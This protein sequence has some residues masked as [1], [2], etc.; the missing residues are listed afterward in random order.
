MKI[1]TTNYFNVFIAVAEDCPVDV[2]L[3]PPKKANT[4]IAELQY[5]LISKNPYQ[6]T[7]DDVVFEVF[8]RKNDFSESEKQEE[9][10][11]F[12]SKGQP[13]LR[14]SALA[15]KYGFGFHHNSQG[16]VALYPIESKEY[17]DFLSSESLTK[18]K[19]MR[20]KKA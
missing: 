12:F 19:A 16:K 5:E 1:H 13:C 8:S 15:K 18:I 9:R 17:K 6:Y 7:S 3:V 10:L 11:K 4:T 14:C 20:S 2:A